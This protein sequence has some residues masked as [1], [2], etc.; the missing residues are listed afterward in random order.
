MMSPHPRGC[1]YPNPWN[2][3][4]C[5]LTQQDVISLKVLRWRRDPGF[6]SEPSVGT[7]FPGREGGRQEGRSPRGAVEGAV[8]PL[9]RCGKGMG[10]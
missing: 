3:C 5:Y 8:L 7:R 6:S 10:A 2:V 1:T 9:W 4:L